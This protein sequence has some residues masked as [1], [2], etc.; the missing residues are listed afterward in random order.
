MPMFTVSKDG[1]SFFDLD[2]T[3]ENREGADKKGYQPY[4]DMTKDGKEHFTLPATKENVDGAM[5]KGYVTVDAFK[6]RGA[7]KADVITKSDSAL[8]GAAQGA[9]L[10]FADEATGAVEAAGKTLFGDEKMADLPANYAKH[11]DESRANYKAAEEAN[12]WSYRGGELGGGLASGIATGGLGAGIKGAAALGAVSGLGA[13]E[14]DL[15]DQALSTAK[16]AGIGAVAGAVGKGIG[17]VLDGSAGDAAR[18]FRR[19]ASDAVSEVK[20]GIP[21]VEQIEKTYAGIKGGLKEISQTAAGKQE[22]AD[23]AQQA[24]QVLHA[25]PESG[26]I[27]KLSDDEAVTQAL[28]ADGPNP[29]KNWYAN[30]SVINNPGQGTADDYLKVLNMSGEERAAARAYDPMKAAGELQP[31]IEDGANTFRNVRNARTQ[32]LQNQA[33]SN[34]QQDDASGLMDHFNSQ[35]EDANKFSSTKSAATV[36]EDAKN[37]IASGKAPKSYGLKEGDLGIMQENGEAGNEELFNR[38]QKARQFLD[39]HIDYNKQGLTEGEKLLKETRGQIDDILKTSPEKVEGD[40]FFRKSKEIENNLVKVTEFR[41]DG[42]TEVD[43]SKIKRLLGDNDAARRFKDSLVEARSFAS[44][45]QLPAD[46]RA[47]MVS[48]VDSIEKQIG[49]ADNSRAMNTLRYKNSGPSGPAIDRMN[50][51]QNKNTLL[52][53]AVNT[54]SGFLNSVDGL[55]KYAMDKTGVSYADMSSSQQLGVTRFWTWMKG[56]QGATEAAANKA[57]T[58]FVGTT[59]NN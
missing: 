43:E 35:I 50:S 32:E 33:R 36:L 47:D 34:F 22:F 28:M 6:N 48:M 37:I 15:S 7:P 8:R 17:K 41:R 24:R 54:P 21:G 25:N 38:L 16:G 5:A 59:P 13:G 40:A 49:V 20:P 4:L 23:V 57:W 3:P 55:K 19:G 56:N 9:S 27:G 14:G 26:A 2:D 1:Q 29:I 30:K 45:E 52:Q 51:I 58:K 46:F 39:N 18:A 44:N 10:G 12:P 11:R 31:T 53:D 42:S